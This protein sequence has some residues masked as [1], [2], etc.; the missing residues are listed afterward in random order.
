MPK[1]GKSSKNKRSPHKNSPNR[2]SPKNKRN[3]NNSNHSNNSTTTSS[4]SSTQ[5]GST[6]Q[7]PSNDKPKS[8]AIILKEKGNIE[9][10]SQNFKKAIECY[11]KAIELE[12]TNHTLYS[13]R[14]AAYKSNGQFSEALE[15]ANKCISLQP[16]WAKGYVRKGTV[17]ATQNK[18]DLAEEV[19]KNG[20]KLCTE[21]EPIRVLSFTTLS[22]I[23]S[24]NRIACNNTKIFSEHWII[25]R[26]SK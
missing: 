9:F 18:L 22:H 21:K 25:W 2:R 14:S 8:P 16:D 10:Q 4:T 24:Q 17:Y 19:Y 7:S 3:S 11:T 6:S 12:A 13:N 5:N 1:R 20:L 26:I 15:D 23:Y